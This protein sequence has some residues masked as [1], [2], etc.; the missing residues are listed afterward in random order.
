M[1]AVT[2]AEREHSINS[3]KSIFLFGAPLVCFR[4]GRKWDSENEGMISIDS[5]G[6]EIPGH[7]TTAWQP[8]NE[9][10]NGVFWFVHID[11]PIFDGHFSDVP[12]I[13]LIPEE[14][15]GSMLPEDHEGRTAREYVSQVIIGL[16][17]NVTVIDN[18]T[19]AS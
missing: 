12:L 7:L 6:K 3:E 2:A 16:D 17:E 15:H 18:F 13:D 4:D 1:I 8:I 10:A 11:D 14:Y 9:D 5:K 19:P